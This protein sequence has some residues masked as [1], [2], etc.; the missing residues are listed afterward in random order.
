M[1]LNAAFVGSFRF[2]GHDGPLLWNA[3]VDAVRLAQS[4]TLGHNGEDELI[5]QAHFLRRKEVTNL[6]VKLIPIGLS[7]NQLVSTFQVVLDPIQFLTLPSCRT[8][9]SDE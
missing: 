9:I 1:N 7:T 5:V 4:L 2:D 6:A 3:P 8:R